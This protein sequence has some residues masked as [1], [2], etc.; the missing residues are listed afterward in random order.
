MHKS[1]EL[2]LTAAYSAI[3]DIDWHDLDSYLVKD[4][5]LCKLETI[6]LKY[7]YRINYNIDDVI[8]TFN[9]ERL[10]LTS[11]LNYVPNEIISILFEFYTIIT[12]LFEDNHYYE[13]KIITDLFKEAMLQCGYLVKY[14]HQEPFNT[15][16][17][18]V[19]ISSN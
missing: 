9:I 12:W 10:N 15:Q 16:L 8:N 2:F 14:Q 1:M 6:M 17:S 4:L 3:F 11:N 7:G 18:L 5:D 19:K 13:I